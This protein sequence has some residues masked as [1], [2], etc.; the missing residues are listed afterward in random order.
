M[1]LHRCIFNYYS[2][3]FSFKINN[4]LKA[5]MFAKMVMIYFFNFFTLHCYL[6]LVD[7]SKI[8]KFVCLALILL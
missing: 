3:F 6:Y 1:L 4:N 2:F 5:V 8:T 7:V